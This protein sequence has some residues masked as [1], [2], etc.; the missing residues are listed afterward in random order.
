MDM[1]K[2]TTKATAAINE[3][4]VYANRNDNSSLEAMHLARAL[5]DQEGGIVTSILKS[6]GSTART[7]SGRTRSGDRTP[8]AG[9]R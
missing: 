7:H 2:F 4:A 9:D 6:P 3:A 1:D 8:S 5:L